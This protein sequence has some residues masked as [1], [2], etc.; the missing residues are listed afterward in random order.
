M[1]SKLPFE[2]LERVDRDIRVALRDVEIDALELLPH[3]VFMPRF[4]ASGCLGARR[5]RLTRCDYAEVDIVKIA[6]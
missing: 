3:H 4:V 6:G 1:W 2:H 5:R